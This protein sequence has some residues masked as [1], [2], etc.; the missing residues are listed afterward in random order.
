MRQPPAIK[1]EALSGSNIR[2]FPQNVNVHEEQNLEEI[3]DYYPEQTDEIVETHPEVD[4]INF[5][6]GTDQQEQIWWAITS[7]RL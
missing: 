1:Q 5:Q 2:K 4:D 6:R 3:Y 7:F